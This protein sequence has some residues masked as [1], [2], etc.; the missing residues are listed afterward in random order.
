MKRVRVVMVLGTQGGNTVAEGVME[1]IMA[2]D[3]HPMVTMTMSESSM[4]QTDEQQVLGPPTPDTVH[5][6]EAG[7]P[8]KP[9]VDDPINLDQFLQTEHGQR[10]FQNWLEGQV[11]DSMVKA[12][13]GADVL[14]LFAVTRTLQES[15]ALGTE[16]LLGEA[17]RVKERG[18]QGENHTTGLEEGKDTALEEKM[19]E[20]MEREQ[21]EMEKDVMDTEDKIEDD[22]TALMQK[23]IH[24]DY[25]A[26]LQ[27]LL[28]ELEGLTKAK[29]ARLSYFLQQLLVDQRRMAPRLRNPVLAERHDR[30]LALLDSAPVL[31]GD[32]TAWCAERWQGLQPFLENARLPEGMRQENQ[33]RP[34]D[35]D[36]S[37]VEVVDSQEM[38]EDGGSRKQMVQLSNG[39]QRELTKQEQ[40]KN[41]ENE[42]MEELAAE[43]LRNE[44]KLLWKEFHAAELTEWESWAVNTGEAVQGNRKRA[45]VQVVVQGQGGRII[46][47][48]NWLLSLGP[49]ERLSYSVSVVPDADK[50]DEDGGD[51]TASSSGADHRDAGNQTI[52]PVQSA[53]PE[54]AA[55]LPVTGECPADMWDEI[56]TS[57]A[58]DL[59]VE[60]FMQTAM[61]AKFYQYWKNGVVTD[62]LIGH[63][64]GCGALG[65]YYSNRLWEQ[66]CFDGM[67]EESGQAT[68]PLMA[69]R[70]DDESFQATQVDHDATSQTMGNGEGMDRE[71]EPDEPEAR[72]LDAG[73]EHG[74]EHPEA[75][76]NLTRARATTSRPETAGTSAGEGPDAVR[77]A[78]E[79]HL[80]G[81]PA[82]STTSTTEGS[83][84]ASS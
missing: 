31:R 63:R 34:S 36:Q 81:Q 10:W 60:D 3:A 78:P 53:R 54:D 83:A 59:D 61:A 68:A 4:M 56:D 44:E 17:S 7:R 18:Q 12:R 55:T 2:V 21:A 62:R 43:E 35:A 40:Q 70:A 23:V 77:P 26:A 20:K 5:V 69:A 42:L 45:R 28:K 74:E 15:H 25:E 48:E 84:A 32:E 24:G 29:A 65:R 67:E 51:P 57:V 13:W 71:D 50:E 76:G 38:I 9:L 39:S 8:R 73:V 30:L 47:N 46:K 58:K 82:A 1:G 66:G 41:L 19:E 22:D 64:F 16:N 11:D 75:T 49:G 6:P 52:G 27:N 33:P 14:E 37:V 79:G 72:C 80:E